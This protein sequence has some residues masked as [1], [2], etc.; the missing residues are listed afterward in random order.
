MPS[1]DAIKKHLESK[2]DG[3]RFFYGGD[4]ILDV[5]KQ[6]HQYSID[7]KNEI[8]YMSHSKALKAMSY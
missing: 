6:L 7:K 3:N 8:K 5:T 4:Q 1:K 2:V